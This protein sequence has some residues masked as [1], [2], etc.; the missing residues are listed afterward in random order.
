M[1][2]PHPHSGELPLGCEVPF[3]VASAPFRR[4]LVAVLLAV[5]AGAPFAQVPGFDEA[6]PAPGDRTVRGALPDGR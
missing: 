4:L 1:P 3:H 2:L 5:A 6:L